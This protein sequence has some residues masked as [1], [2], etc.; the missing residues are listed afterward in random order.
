[1]RCLLSEAAG[2]PSF[3]WLCVSRVEADG[4]W[5]EKAYRQQRTPFD[6]PPEYGARLR[7]A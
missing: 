7:F 6:G 2:T 1:M 4:E 3:I 5:N